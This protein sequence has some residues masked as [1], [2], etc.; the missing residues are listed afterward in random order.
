MKIQVVF[1]EDVTQVGANIVEFSVQPTTSIIE[2]I[3][4]GEFTAGLEDKK[5]DA[6]LD[7][8]AEF[9]TV[10]MVRLGLVVHVK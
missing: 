3:A 2:P 10:E 1:P 6:L 9:A 4:W 7:K 5:A 8:V